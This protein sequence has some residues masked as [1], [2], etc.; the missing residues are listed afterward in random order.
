[1]TTRKA[2]T[3]KIHARSLRRDFGARR[4]LD[5]GDARD[6]DADFVMEGVNAG[7]N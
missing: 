2:N 4:R 3:P 5:E 1:M 7:S 6:V